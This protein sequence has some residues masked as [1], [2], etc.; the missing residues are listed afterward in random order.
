MA[1]WREDMQTARA[2]HQSAW[3]RKASDLAQQQ[4]HICSK[5]AAQA[6]VRAERRQ[7][8]GEQRA[9]LPADGGEANSAREFLRP[10]HPVLVT[11]LRRLDNKRS[12]TEGLG[13]ALAALVRDVVGAADELDGKETD[14]TNGESERASS[15][16]ITH[17]S[18]LRSLL[19][20]ALHSVNVDRPIEPQ[21]ALAEVLEQISP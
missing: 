5:R 6:A 3:Q 9:A 8:V 7:T 13:T 17:A 12:S 2:S 4:Q 11:A 14:S 15:F 18:D 10:L 19:L 20:Q 1:Q 16:L 21:I